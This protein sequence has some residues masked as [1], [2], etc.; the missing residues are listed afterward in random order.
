M[1]TF[2]PAPAAST[3][4]RKPWRSRRSSNRLTKTNTREPG[5][6]AQV[7]QHRLAPKKSIKRI[8][9]TQSGEAI[10]VAESDY[11]SVN[12]YGDVW[13][14]GGDGIHA[15]STAVAVAK[16]EQE[17]N[18]TNTSDSNRDHHRGSL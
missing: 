6:R 1:E 16:V 15:D 10:A 5:R 9:A 13:N 8:A 17:A 11:V 18:Q 4:S 3:P 14:S 7:R 12:N 2:R